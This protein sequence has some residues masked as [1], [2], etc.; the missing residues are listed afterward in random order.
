VALF[1]EMAHAVDFASGTWTDPGSSETK[2]GV[3]ENVYRASAGLPQ[4]SGRGGGCNAAPA[5]NP[6]PQNSGCFIAT[7]AFGSPIEAEVQMLRSFRDDVLRRTRAGQEFFDEFWAHYYKLSPVV[8]GMMDKDPAIRDMVRWSIVTPIVRQLETLLAFP[9][10][11]LTGLPEPW[12]SFIAKMRDDFE[13]WT[14]EVELPRTFL[15]VDVTAAAQEIAI[16]LRY[17]LRT[18]SRRADYLA[19]L[20][21]RGE[22]PLRGSP[23][24]LQDARGSLSRHGLATDLAERVVPAAARSASAGCCGDVV[25]RYLNTDESVF[26]SSLPSADWIYQVTITNQSGQL[27]DQI[28]LFYDQT[29]AIGAVIGLFDNTVQN[30]QVSV[31]NLGPCGLLNS[32]V[33]G[34]FQGSDKVAQMPNSDP[35]WQGQSAITPAL[36]HAIK[37]NDPPCADGWTIT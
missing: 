19:D 20:E 18:A 3:A 27:F 10:A 29:D 21:R 36:A 31:F 33:V 15:D 12:L 11:P 32:Y 28:A 34:F 17:M 13:S 22:I 8:V 23:A 14:G 26:A 16:V 25:A 5:G 37:P 4:R 35:I 7:A 30:G 24:E 2:A 9:D 6:P 1:H